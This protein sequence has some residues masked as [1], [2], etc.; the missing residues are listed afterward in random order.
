MVNKRRII[1]LTSYQTDG[2]EDRGQA[3]RSVGAKSVRSANCPSSVIVGLAVSFSRRASK[4]YTVHYIRRR[5]LFTLQLQ[6]RPA[7]LIAL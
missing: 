5:R 1:S 6:T 7:R 2:G 4:W 3:G